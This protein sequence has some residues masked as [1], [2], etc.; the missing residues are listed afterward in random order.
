MISNVC[1]M[2]H[3]DDGNRTVQI[4]RACAD[5]VAKVMASLR[6]G[7]SHLDTPVSRAI[8]QTVAFAA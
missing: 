5:T 3:P 4:A 8:L 2:L 7:L 6:D 1:G